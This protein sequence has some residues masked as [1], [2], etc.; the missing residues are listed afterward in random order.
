LPAPYKGDW[1]LV[2]K[3]AGGRTVFVELNQP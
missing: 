3:I 1:L 2:R